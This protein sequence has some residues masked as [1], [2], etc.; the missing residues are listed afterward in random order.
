[1]LKR[2]AVGID[3]G[4]H[5]IKAVDV[6]VSDRGL[7]VSRA[8]FVERSELAAKG[9]EPGN[10]SQLARMLR[11]ELDGAKISPRGVVLGIG[12]Q[13]SMMRYT[14]IPPV[15]SWRLKVIMNYEVG[16]ISERI[17]EPLA[18]DYSVLQLAREADE[19]QTVLIGLAKEKPLAD[20]LEALEREGITV[21]K[22]VPSAMAIFTLQDAFGQ[23]TDQDSA[24]DDLLLLADMGGENLS[25][26]LLLN[27][28]LAFARTVTYGG[29]NFTEALAQDLGIDFAE[30]ERLKMSRGGL[31][32]RDRGVHADSIRA[33]RGAAGQLLGMLQSSLK[34]SATQTGVSLPPLSRAL[35]LGGG[36]R[37]RGL[38]AFLQQG[39]GK[40]VDF[41]R[42]AMNLASTLPPPLS[43]ALS[44]R[45]GDFGVAL[46]LG[47]SRLRDA[48][49]EK[50]KS[51][52]T[53]LPAKYVEKREFKDRTLFLYAAGVF[54]VVFLA[55]RLIHGFVQNSKAG[56]MHRNLLQDYRQLEAS[57]KDLEETSRQANER[58]ARLNRLLKE[59]EQ[60]AFQ[61]YVLDL[62]SRV[63]RPEIQLDR[64]ALDF[65]SLSEDETSFDYNLR[66]IGRVNNERHQGLDWILDLQSTLKSDPRIA[67]V[68][69]ESS[70]PEGAWYKFELS[71]KPNYVSY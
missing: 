70:N 11:A 30:A 42:P 13:D 22:A 35:L 44:E 61:A 50:P 32:E 68:D 25:I 58:Q 53:I 69:V 14:R 52:L 1:M 41:F 57:K 33:L 2:S 54:L 62:L 55:A 26:A 39:L 59:G 12:G 27:G 5:A 60:T 45:P 7:T 65:T 23:K 43:S 4:A 38:P 10:V 40:P 36:M 56:E 17:G 19:D 63:L 64:I 24:E 66:L 71:V 49:S 21:E 20:L 29:K 31:D 6:K 67:S 28:R 34:F 18:S 8:L 46:G 16:E 48:G 37:L 47:T 9:L 3:F 51:G 15:P